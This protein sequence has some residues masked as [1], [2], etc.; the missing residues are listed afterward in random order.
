MVEAFVHEHDKL[1]HLH[2]N[3]EKLF[4]RAVASAEEEE[5]ENVTLCGF[6]QRGEER[7]K[8]VCVVKAG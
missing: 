1:P 4:P 7:G 8:A 2:G 6:E 3:L 5:A